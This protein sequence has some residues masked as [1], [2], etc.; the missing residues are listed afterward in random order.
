[1]FSSYRGIYLNGVKMEVC[2]DCG[3]PTSNF[4]KIPRSEL[5]RCSECHEIALVRGDRYSP[6]IA[7][8]DYNSQRKGKGKTIKKKKR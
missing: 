4:Y 6:G 1:M 7:K 8:R 5:V 2:I 3:K